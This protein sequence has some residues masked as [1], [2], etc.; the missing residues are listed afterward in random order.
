M[1]VAVPI[2]AQSVYNKGICGIPTSDIGS[3]SFIMNVP[4]DRAS[5]LVWPAH[6][7]PGL[8]VPYIALGV[9]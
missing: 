9:E 2:L 1:R 5:E 6:G 3:A 7:G 4:N 8:Y